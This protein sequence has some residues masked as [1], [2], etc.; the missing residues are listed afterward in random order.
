MHGRVI[1]PA[2]TWPWKF[3][4]QTEHFKQTSYVRRF[5]IVM[6]YFIKR[7]TLFNS[8]DLFTV[9]AWNYVWYWNPTHLQSVKWT[10]HGRVNRRAHTWPW[11]FPLQT[12]I[13]RH[14]EKNN[15]AIA[16]PSIWTT[17][18]RSVSLH[19]SNYNLIIYSEF[20]PIIKAAV[21]G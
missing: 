2:Q 16:I 3:P 4:L 12:N 7:R 10:M 11:K 15:R 9:P 6:I 1:R 20:R 17:S 5:L 8:D 18:D 14:D 13:V 19:H 21:D